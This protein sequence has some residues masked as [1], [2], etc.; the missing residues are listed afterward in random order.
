MYLLNN[1]AMNCCGCGSC[2]QIC[3]VTCITM[4]AANDGFSYPVINEEACIDCAKC[5]NA[6]PFHESNKSAEHVQKTRCYYGWHNNDYIRKDSTSGGAFSAIAEVVFNQ[7]NTTVYGALFD[8]NWTVCHK[9]IDKL[10]DLDSLRQSKYVQSEIGNCYVE[11]RGKL[12]N[13]EHVLFCGTPCQVHGLRTFLRKDYDKLL[14]VD[15]ICHGVTS[16][17]AFHMYICSL[18]KSEKSSVTN[19][20]FRD[21]VSRGN[22][23][24][25][26]YTT[27]E[28]ENKK[29]K[30]TEINSYLMAYMKGVMQRASCEKCPYATLHRQSDLTMG[31]FWGIEN[32][33]HNIKKE[34]Y[35]GISLIL[36]NTEKG[37]LICNKL[38]KVMTLTET[39]VSWALNGKN[40]QLIKPV[41][42]NINKKQFF[43]DSKTMPIRL[44]LLKGI[45]L[46]DIFLLYLGAFKSSIKANLPRVIYNWLLS[47]R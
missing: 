17:A 40:A 29:S 20:R 24:S 30:S 7:N 43:V 28:F 10:D 25:L 33:V 45:G 46:K 47:L 1:H 35:K 21:K 3:P 34:F 13:D 27:I 2:Q 26:A 39:D 42:G 37:H 41:S 19:F 31:D 12:Q 22:I 32:Y 38:S 8:E 5:Y 16:P 9:G 4:Q 23:K 11:I 14:L 44:A 18:E 6:C 15:F 36:S